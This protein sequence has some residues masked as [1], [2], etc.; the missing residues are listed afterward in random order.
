MLINTWH[1][2]EHLQNLHAWQSYN[3]T[4]VNQSCLRFCMPLLTLVSLQVDFARLC[5][6]VSQAVLEVMG[7]PPSPFGGPGFIGSW[8]PETMQGSQMLKWAEVTL[9]NELQIKHSVNAALQSSRYLEVVHTAYD[10]VL[11]GAPHLQRLATFQ[12][13]LHGKLSDRVTKALLAAKPVVD[14]L[15]RASIQQLLCCSALS[16][17]H[18]ELKVRVSRC[19][20]RHVVELVKTKPIV[21][22][23]MRE[24]KQV[25]QQRAD[26]VQKWANLDEAALKIKSIEKEFVNDNYEDEV[27]QSLLDAAKAL[28]PEKMPAAIQ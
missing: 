6:D 14:E 18:G 22:S 13:T 27:L 24:D 15:A 10:D 4:S 17:V 20:V 8:S 5:R 2:T 19:I 26:L 25:A 3:S 16:F 23:K 21:L 1:G 9:D 28:E 7:D 11:R 12:V